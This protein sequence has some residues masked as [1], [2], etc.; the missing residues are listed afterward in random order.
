MLDKRRVEG[1]TFF[2]FDLSSL[3]CI[4]RGPRGVAAERGEVF[5]KTNLN[6]KSGRPL[7]NN[8]RPD[9]KLSPRLASL[10]PP[11]NF[12]PECLYDALQVLQ[13]RQT[14]HAKRQARVQARSRFKPR[15]GNRSLLSIRSDP[16][17]SNVAWDVARQA[18]FS[19]LFK[20]SSN[21]FA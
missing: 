7:R 10:A 9:F 11:L 17:H 12:A 2:I 8:S 1:P 4:L 13:V 18:S 19:N 3:I 14:T 15:R 5:A 16:T 21:P 20:L 6:L